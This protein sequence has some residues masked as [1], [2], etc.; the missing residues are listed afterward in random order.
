MKFLTFLTVA[1][2]LYWGISLIAEESLTSR[3]FQEIVPGKRKLFAGNSDRETFLAASIL[4]L[5]AGLLYLTW[6]NL[7]AFWLYLLIAA[8]CY[9]FLHAGKAKR[10]YRKWQ[11]Q[12]DLELPGLTQALTLMISAG[13]S[14]MRAMQVISSRSNS[15]AARE[16]RQVV[17]EVVDGKSTVKAIDDFAGRVKSTGTRRLCNA[18]S[19]AIERGTP[20]VPVLTALLKDAQVDS[21]NE[22]LRR[23]GKAEIALM[24][25]VVFLLLPISVLFALFP[26]I[27]QLQGF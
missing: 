9:S 19:I 1:P 25:P 11:R 16:L 20:L 17:K 26:S 22:L 5:F 10:E 7:S 3:K 4:L 13:I 14:P 21:R 23:A 2:M 15:I 8:A 27:T 18:L 24:L 6:K 12:V